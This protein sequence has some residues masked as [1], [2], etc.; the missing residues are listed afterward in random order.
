MTAPGSSGDAASLSGR[1]DA[2]RPGRNRRDATPKRVSG[3]RA[4]AG[5]GHGPEVPS[6]RGHG[7]IARSERRGPFGRAARFEATRHTDAVAG[8][9]AAAGSVATDICCRRSI[10]ALPCCVGI[11]RSSRSACGHFG[12]V[13]GPRNSG[14][15][16]LFPAPAEFLARSSFTDRTARRSGSRFSS[17]RLDAGRGRRLDRTEDRPEPLSPITPRAS[18]SQAPWA[19][20]RGLQSPSR[21]RCRVS[22]CP[23]WGLSANDARVSLSAAAPCQTNPQPRSRSWGHR[24]RRSPAECCAPR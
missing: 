6:E 12:G 2:Q 13:D 15:P 7:Q 10:S 16:V 14:S 21:R 1:G 19:R 20:F 23:R 3:P 4:P 18:V 17:S 5:C 22:K 9:A 8:A 11:R 24:P